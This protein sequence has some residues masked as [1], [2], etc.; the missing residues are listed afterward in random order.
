M[1]KGT[2][3]KGLALNLC[4]CTAINFGTN[5]MKKGMQLC[6][7]GASACRWR[8][9]WYFGV[10]CFVA[11]NICNF[12]SF[13]MAPQSLLASMSASQFV[14]NVFFARC[15]LGEEITRR[16]I[17][18]TCL[19]VTGALIAV[20]CASHEKK[21]YTPE[22]LIENY[23]LSYF[24][25]LCVQAVAL[26]GFELMYRRARQESAL[27]PICYGGVSAILGT[28]SVVQA[29]CLSELAGHGYLTRSSLVF[30]VLPILIAAQA[31][32]LVRMQRGLLQ[33]KGLIIIP[34]LQV[35]WTSLSIL[36]GGIY[37]REFGHMTPFLA[38]LFVLGLVILFG[39]VW[40]LVPSEAV[41]EKPDETESEVL[42][43]QM[44]RT[45]LYVG[46]GQM[47]ILCINSSFAASPDGPPIDALVASFGKPTQAIMERLTQ[48][49][50]NL[51]TVPSIEMAT[52]TIR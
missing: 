16:T 5:C 33:F 37:F 23:S 41:V 30:L 39:G 38:V 43:R 19:I 27:S 2:V 32:W 11:G 25:Y 20:Q 50:V 28:Q 34:V 44:Y 7:D 15:L 24:A 8:L 40:F 35:W 18:A 12:V 17:I 31:F 45:S 42:Y 51:G 13:G 52:T 21:R 46:P 6:S 49:S 48:R 4:G 47:D 29:K 36:T 26:V 9:V 10:M 22:D 3:A 1:G 14:T